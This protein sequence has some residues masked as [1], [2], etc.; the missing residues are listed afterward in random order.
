M[1]RGFLIRMFAEKNKRRTLT[2][3]A[4]ITKNRTVK[5]KWFIMGPFVTSLRWFSHQF[6]WPQGGTKVLYGRRAFYKMTNF[7]TKHH[8]NLRFKYFFLFRYLLMSKSTVCKVILMWR[9]PSRTDLNR[10][11]PTRLDPPS[12]FAVIKGVPQKNPPDDFFVK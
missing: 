1:R 10:P 5:G 11:K 3:D 8:Y 12:N 9:E 2:C 7:D 4:W 6:W